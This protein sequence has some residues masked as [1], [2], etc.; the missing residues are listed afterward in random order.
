MEQKLLIE[1]QTRLEFQEETI[2]QLGQTLTAQQRELQA[3]R[4]DV[5]RLQD[6]VR[7]LTPPL[8]GQ[9]GDEPPPPHY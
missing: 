9:P 5:A 1:L 3:L 7:R 6:L 2:E 8:T 4:T